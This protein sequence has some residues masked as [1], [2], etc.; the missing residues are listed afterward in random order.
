VRQWARRAVALRS[1]LEGVADVR[2]V[3]WWLLAGGAALDWTSPGAYVASDAEPAADTFI[4][5]VAPPPRDALA[6][7]LVRAHAARAALRELDGQLPEQPLAVTV[8]RSPHGAIAVP[9]PLDV[10][11][12]AIGDRVITHRLAPRIEDETG[13]LVPAAGVPFVTVTLGD[14]PIETAR[15]GHRRAWRT[16]GA[17]TGPW[18][19][20]GRAGGLAIV[21]TCH[22]IVDGYGHALLAARIADHAARVRASVRALP[23]L[24][25]PPPCPVA[26][27]IPLAVTWR[28]LPQPAPRALPVA[29]SSTPRYVARDACKPSPLSCGRSTSITMSPVASASASFASK[30]SRDSCG[31]STHARGPTTRTSRRGISAFAHA[32]RKVFAGTAAP[33][34]V[35]FMASCS[36]VPRASRSDPSW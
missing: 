21:S 1:E 3:R 14:E 30:A 13:E 29:S 6:D 23:P 9:S 16:N 27:A 34:T 32:A 11:A 25:V 8:K 35:A 5:Q 18:L 19:G 36:C 33:T 12:L 7:A 15:H 22:M 17:A 2:D 24:A 28:P 31:S 20:L 4:G 10:A 26:G